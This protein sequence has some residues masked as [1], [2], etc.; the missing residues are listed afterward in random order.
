MKNTLSSPAENANISILNNPANVSKFKKSNKINAG[1][2]RQ[3]LDQVLS[4]QRLSVK[5]GKTVLLYL[6]T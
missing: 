6:F 1:T 2:R 3:S 4:T 5:I